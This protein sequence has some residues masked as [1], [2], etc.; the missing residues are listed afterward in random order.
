VT[1]PSLPTI[2]LDTIRYQRREVVSDDVVV[3]MKE[4]TP[5]KS[6]SRVDWRV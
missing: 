4:V 1:E 6:I 5:S 3:T 2:S